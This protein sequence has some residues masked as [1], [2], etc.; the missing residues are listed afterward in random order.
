M[1]K[2]TSLLL[3]ENYFGNIF[4]LFCTNIL[5]HES[6]VE[7]HD[8]VRKLGDS[9]RDCNTNFGTTLQGNDVALMVIKLVRDMMKNEPADLCGFTSWCRFPIYEADF[10]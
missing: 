8:L 4:T 6:K 10:G 3:L 9:I 2:K 7:L 5:V 1:D